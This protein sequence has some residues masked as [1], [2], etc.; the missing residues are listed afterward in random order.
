MPSSWNVYYVIFLSALLALGI[1]AALALVSFLVLKKRP[2]K[3]L[4]QEVL[5][6]VPAVNETVLGKRINARFFLGVNA[7]L[8]LIALGLALIPCAGMLKKGADDFALSRALIAIVSLG[9][10]TA[11]GL[12]YSAKKGDLS[13]LKTYQSGDAGASPCAKERE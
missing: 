4:V 10:L 5:D 1:P 13:W 11:L 7:G 2:R 3:R 12:L 9:T 6:E 8:V